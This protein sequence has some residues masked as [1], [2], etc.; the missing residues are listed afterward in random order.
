ME[1]VNPKHPSKTNSGC[2][3]WGRNQPWITGD[4]CRGTVLLIMESGVMEM[5]PEFARS[6]AQEILT[7][8]DDVGATSDRGGK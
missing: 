1:H 8:C 4:R 6:F 3:L 7:H 5:T 2:L